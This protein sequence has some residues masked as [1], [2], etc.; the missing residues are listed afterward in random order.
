[1]GPYPDWVYYPSRSR[2]PAWVDSLSTWSSKLGRTFD[3]PQSTVS[4]V[5]SCPQGGPPARLGIVTAHAAAGGPRLAVWRNARGDTGPT[6]TRMVRRRHR[7]R[8]RLGPEHGVR[9]AGE[10]AA[11]ALPAA[12]RAHGAD[13]P[14]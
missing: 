1:M 6:P 10:P 13:R 7:Q 14:A 5:M 8:V 3:R 9:G 4:P 11:P 12:R 2:A